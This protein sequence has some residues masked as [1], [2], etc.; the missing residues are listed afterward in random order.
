M[1]GHW[2]LFAYC[3]LVI[4]WWLYLGYWLLF[5]YCILVIG[6]FTEIYEEI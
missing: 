3:F 4:V 1:F 6:Y 5:D 2:L